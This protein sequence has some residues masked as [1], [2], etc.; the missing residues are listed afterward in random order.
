MSSYGES[1]A[2]S[3]SQSRRNGWDFAPNGKEGKLANGHCGGMNYEARSS[4]ILTSF[5]RLLLK[6][7]DYTK[8]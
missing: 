2:D 8:L 3:S 6:C 4:T 1:T 5:S 7:K